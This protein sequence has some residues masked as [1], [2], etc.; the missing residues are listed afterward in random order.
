MASHEH[1]TGHMQPKPN[2]V[3]DPVCGM[4]VD[5]ET[6]RGAAEYQGKTYYFGSSRCEERFRAEP[7]KYLAAKP[8]PG[9][10]V[11]LGGITPVKLESL[12]AGVAG[13]KA[14]TYVCPMDVEARGG[15][16]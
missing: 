16:Q 12:G 15:R 1:M 2:T 6:A 11:Q 9:N 4:Y 7:E 13:N 5:P 10:L 8:M 14:V 3:L